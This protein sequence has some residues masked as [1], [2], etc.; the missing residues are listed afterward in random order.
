MY[1]DASFGLGGFGGGGRGVG[2]ASRGGFMADWRQGYTW[3]WTQRLSAGGP[4][5]A[6]RR[7]GRLTRAQVAVG[8][9]SR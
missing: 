6:W 8:G 5:P 1:P 9:S 2:L 7:C 4:A 3:D